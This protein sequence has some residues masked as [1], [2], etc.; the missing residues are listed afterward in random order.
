MH[1]FDL[2]RFIL[3]SEVEEDF[4]ASRW[5]QWEDETATVTARTANGVLVVADLQRR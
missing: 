3:L 2:W 1:H 5:G 4:A